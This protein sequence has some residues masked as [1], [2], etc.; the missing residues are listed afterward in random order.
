[1]GRVDE[2]ELVNK[3]M[4]SSRVKDFSVR[5]RQSHPR[6]DGPPADYPRWFASEQWQLLGNMTAANK[7]GAQIFRLPFPA[8]VR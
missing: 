2:V 8:R 1:M 3:E 5:G 4:Y 6:K 7:K